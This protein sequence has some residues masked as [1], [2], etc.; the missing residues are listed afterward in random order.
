MSINMEIPNIKLQVPNEESL[1][2][3]ACHLVLRAKRGYTLIELIVSVGLFAIIM[4]LASGAYLIMINVNRQTQAIATG[5]NNLSFALESMT[6]SIRTGRSYSQ[7][8]GPNTFSFIDQSGCSIT[9]GVSAGRIVQ[10]ESGT[11]CPSLSNTP[12]TAPSVNVTSLMFSY[13]DT[14]R[15]DDYQPYVTMVVS[16]TVSS[17]PGQ[18]EPFTVETSATMRGTD[19]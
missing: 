5:I 10:T 16:G 8:V 4:M 3:G 13:S 19:L 2:F 6:R 14:P 18:T 1:A 17:G 12:L 15:G 9:Y 11:G 7:L